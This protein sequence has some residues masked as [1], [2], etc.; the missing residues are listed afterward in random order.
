MIFLCAAFVEAETEVQLEVKIS[1]GHRT[2]SVTPFYVKL[3]GQGTTL[4]DPTG[5]EF[6][7]GDGFRDGAY[8]TRAGGG[9]VDGVELTMRYP[10]TPVRTIEKLHPLWGSLIA[11]SDPDTVRRLR[12]DPAYRLDARKMTV[13]MNAEGTKGF[14]VTVDQLVVN[15][16]FWV[17]SLD[18]Y[19]ATGDRPVSFVDHQKELAPWKGKRILEQVH[20][21]TEATYEQYA[22]RWEDM[23]NPKYV[24][25]AQP[26]PGHI[27]C[28]TWD[29]AIHKFGIDR[30]AGVWNDY[31]NP[32]RFRF[33]F[34]FGDLAAGIA[35][36]WKGQRLVDGFPVVITV[37]E[38]DSVRYEVE[39]F[40]YPLNGPP[41]ERRGDIPM[42]LLQKVKLTELSG[43][44]RSVSITL[45]HT[46]K[47]SPEADLVMDRQGGRISVVDTVGKRALFTVEDVTG[48]AALSPAVDVE[49]GMRRVGVT[50]TVEL[51]A[52]ESQELVVKLPSPVVDSDGRAI[53]AALDYEA[54]RT[55]TLKFWGDYE[56][57]GARFHVPEK[58][59]NELFR[60]N[61]WHALRLPRRH[62]GEGASVRIDLPYSNFAY[63]QTGIPWPVNQSIYVDYMIYDLRGYHNV[64][65]EELGAILR[66]NLEPNGHIKGYANWLVYTPSTLYAVG[67]NYL[68]S[69]DRPA[70]ERLLPPSLRVMDWCLGQVREARDRSG[71]ARG[72]VHGPLNDGTGVGYWAFNQ[73]YAFAGLDLFGKA[74]QRYGHP[75][76]AECLAAARDFQRSV[77]RAFG[78]AA[79][80]SPLVQLRDHT[81]IP[82]VPC[83]ATRFGRLLDQWYPTDVDTGAVHLLRLKAI[84]A[85][86]DLAESLLND[87]EDN[88]YLHGWGMANEPVYNPQ[89]T[90]YLLRD[91]PKAVIRTFYSMMACAFSHSVYEA[92]E[93]RWSHGQYFC[94]PSTDG[95][96]SELYRNM[97]VQELD[98]DTLFLFAAT[99]RKWLEHGKEIEIERAPTYYGKL[100]ARLESQAEKGKI[101]A[102][103]EM[104][105]AGR[106]KA[107]VIRFRHPRGSPMRSVEVNGRTFENFDARKEW[108]PIEKPTARHYS[109]VATY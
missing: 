100:S 1:W 74:L 47:L 92:V 80:R 46:R 20:R 59:V 21:E 13:Q 86:G 51:R 10:E 35:Q 105:R 30:G 66:D 102:E 27:V 22:S 48:S 23:G 70:F 68:L 26:A 58:A 52:N 61:L 73:A 8:E 9:D 37:V 31:G 62:G 75:R 39:Q 71:S 77:N 95:A 17:P 104:P 84:P 12:S 3:M 41:S 43:E 98:D 44:R 56:A 19:L 15:G 38:K 85:D 50:I 64:A 99:P 81:W 4:S 72:L 49:G 79:M 82:Y 33:W 67:K 76:A 101:L 25:P 94:P 42:V 14:T 6:E 91:D 18:V 7:S 34:D 40:A 88:L 55:A 5:Q 96:W 29:S 57:S 90:A 93:H 65:A 103:I 36:S 16:V 32:D 106:P 2:P 54:A 83:E 63:T 97:L 107:L 109:I 87:H 11:Q 60:A 78:A 108:I 89:G 45:N 53:L 28:L 24:H 69:H